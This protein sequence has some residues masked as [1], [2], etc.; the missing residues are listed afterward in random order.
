MFGLSST[1][2]EMVTPENALPGRSQPIPTAREHSVLGTTLDPEAPEGFEVAMFGMGCFWGAE[3]RF[4]E[5]SGVFTTAVGYAGG[6][7]QN[8]HYE[9]VC[10]G[11]TGHNEVVRVVFELEP[12]LFFRFAEPT[13]LHQSS[14]EPVSRR[15][16]QWLGLV[17]V[18]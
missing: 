18:H 8:P 5:C 1:K 17:V 12:V 16:G 2:T 6:H 15:E 13:G 10:T 14:T 11:R 4:W 9:E 3:R 7:T